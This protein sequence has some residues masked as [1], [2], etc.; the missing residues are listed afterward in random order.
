MH[1]DVYC[2]ASA[3]YQIRERER[4]RGLERGEKERKIIRER[5]NV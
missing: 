5:K 3:T 1:D 2:D 4:E